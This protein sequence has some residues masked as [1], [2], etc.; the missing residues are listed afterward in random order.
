MF[1]L[2]GRLCAECCYH[3]AIN[4]KG[5]GKEGSNDLNDFLSCCSIGGEVSSW[6]GYCS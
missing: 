3:G 5:I 4:G 1:F 2:F 6:I